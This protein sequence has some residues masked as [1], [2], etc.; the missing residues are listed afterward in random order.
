MDVD[1]NIDIAADRFQI[2][3]ESI[4]NITLTQYMAKVSI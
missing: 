4:Y 2:Y 1:P 3:K